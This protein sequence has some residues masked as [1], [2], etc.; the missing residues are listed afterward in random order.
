[1]K[2]D[3]WNKSKDMMTVGKGFLVD[4]IGRAFRPRQMY[5]ASKDD[6][7]IKHAE[8]RAQDTETQQMFYGWKR[9]VAYADSENLYNN[10][11]AGSTIDIC[12]RLTIGNAGGV[13]QFTGDNAKENQDRFDAWKK[14]CGFYEDENYIDMLKLIL[15]AVKIK[16][17]CIVLLDPVLTNNKLRVFDADQ[18]TPVSPADFIQW[19]DKVGGYDGEQKQENRWRQ[20]EGAVVN[21]Q[22]RCIGWFVTMLRNRAAVALSDAAF[23]PMGIGIRVSSRKM[24]TQYRGEPILL[25][26]LPITKSTHDLIGSEVQG[27]KNAAEL[28]LAVIDGEDS[29]GD[30]A[31]ALLNGMTSDQASEGT[32]ITAEQLEEIRKKTQGSNTFEALAGK[33][34]IGH[35]R[36]G[37]Q[38]QSLDNTNRPSMSIQEWMNNLSDVNAHRYGV[39][40]CLGRGHS[41]HSY[42]AG[43][44][45]LTISWVT[46]GEDQKMLERYVV[47]YICNIMF[48]GASYIVKWPKAFDIDPMKSE[49][50]NRLKLQNG[51][52][53]F[54]EY[55][56]PRYLEIFDQMAFEKQELEKRNL[57]N[58]SIFQSNAGNQMDTPS[59]PSDNEPRKEN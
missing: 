15:H 29:V 57:N 26:N 17:D 23:I 21:T 49:Q 18:I 4:L 32:G 44:M 51:G 55:L 54:R 37:T 11:S 9:I 34:A 25:P 28:S 48:P 27:A 42:S 12:I 10:D 2:L 5:E 7:T 58:L 19:C 30:Q 47:D 3:F 59:E 33:S 24:L 52:M 20:V 50:T 35:F 56:G 22:G 6:P 13:P 53:T 46:L 8:I 38:I 41:E 39:M 31:A 45:E 14:K 40:S 43:Q 36:H 16:G 1:M